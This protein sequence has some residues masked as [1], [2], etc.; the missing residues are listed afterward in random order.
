MKQRYAIVWNKES[1]KE[2]TT[3][4]I[5]FL[6]SPF[7]AFVYSLKNIKTRSSFVV[8]FWTA[9]FFG[10][11]MVYA[12][13]NK[14]DGHWHAYDFQTYV[15][16]TSSQYW[17]KVHSFFSFDNILEVKDLYDVTVKYLVSHVT[18]N[19]HVFFM[20]L[21]IVFAFFS[22]K[23]F[24][25]FTS[26]SKFDK[27]LMAYILAYIFMSI[28]IFEINGVRFYTAAWIALL[29]LFKI[30]REGDNRYVWLAAITPGE[31]LAERQ[32]EASAGCGTAHSPCGNRCTKPSI[33]AAERF[34]PVLP[35]VQGE[36]SSARRMREEPG[37]G[38]IRTA[39][40]DRADGG[41]RALG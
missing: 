4:L 30:F 27:S 12:P 16:M 38:R 40:C 25:I 13:D 33:V 20:V 37:A 31:Q 35:W 3:K 9:I 19:Y 24:K 41:R 15:T 28:Q 21:A 6:L 14:F 26:E 34:L 32:C 5:L 39:A 7:L 18:G 8:F 36:R 23:T 11:S 17:A 10:M 1:S 22:L 29:C 2:G